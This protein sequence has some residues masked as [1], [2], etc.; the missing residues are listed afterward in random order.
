MRNREDGDTE[1]IR[2]SYQFIAGEPKLAEIVDTGA[3]RKLGDLL[4]SIDRRSVEQASE[5]MASQGATQ[6]ALEAREELIRRHLIPI[7]K[8]AALLATSYPPLKAL[9]IP[10]RDCAVPTLVKQA[11]GMSVEARKYQEHFVEEGLRPD[12]LEQLDLAIQRFKEASAEPRQHRSK[13][14]GA[15]SG[16]EVDLKKAKKSLK[17]LDSFVQAAAHDDASVLSGWNAVKRFP[18]RKKPVAEAQELPPAAP[19]P[20]MIPAPAEPLKL[21]ARVEEN[22]PAERPA[23]WTLKILF[24]I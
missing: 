17:V 13:R 24:R 20:L 3:Y 19:P 12:F 6:A 14:S 18:R 21:T 8:V 4:D 22:E 10:D 23:R 16:A 2:A 7:A 9:R 15:T 11:S 1:I 5:G